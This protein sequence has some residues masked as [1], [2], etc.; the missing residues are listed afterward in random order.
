MYVLEV[1]PLSRTAPPHPLS[2][3]NRENLAPGTIISIPLRKKIVAGL[4]VASIPVREAKA[5]IKTASFSL[6]KSST[7]EVGVLPM[8]LMKAASAIALYYATTVGAVLS[9]LLVPVLPER[10]PTRFIKGTGFSIQPIEKPMLGRK[11]YYEDVL[12]E[13]KKSKGTTLLVVSTQAE[14]DEW[15]NFYK[16]LKPLVLSG[17]LS[18]KRRETAMARAV[19]AAIDETSV[20]TRTAAPSLIIATPGFSWIPIPHLSR[21]IIERVSA[22]SYVLPKRPHINIVVALTELARARNIP[23]VYG[24]YP[25]PLEYRS[26]PSK[27]LTEKPLGTITLFDV[28][29][30]KEDD[31]ITGATWKAIPDTILTQI[32]DV[33]EKNGRVAVLAVRKGYAPT[34]VCRD[35]GTA[36]IDEQGRALSL[37]I[38]NGKRILRSTDGATIESAK[39]LCKHC[40]SWNLMPLGIG[41]E[42]VEEEL[43]KTFPDSEDSII[44]GTEAM[45]STLSLEDPVDLGIVASADALLSLPFWRA[46]ER[47]VRIG[48]MLAE[49]SKKVIV[50]SRHEG[51][52]A[53]LTALTSPTTSSFW[54][55]ELALRKAL[56]YPPFGT[57]IWFLVGGSA[58][59]IEDARALITNVCAP[60]T[61]IHLAPRP[62]SASILRGISVLQLPDGAWPDETLS[63]RI[64][65]LSPVIRVHIDS[66]SL[67]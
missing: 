65:E 59:R 64:S 3:R 49:R 67:W 28:R 7:S 17:K 44:V 23:V 4:V 31:K 43:R 14:A 37:S 13:E 53:A 35:C 60:L 38:A 46:R 12:G 45:L 20:S 56:H 41:V 48:L 10:I 51:T 26:N 42:R 9:A 39:A 25:L 1:I 29:A 58:A 63:A 50:A 5:Q 15:A 34:V 47:F 57:L 19:G 30:Q 32:R 61:P 16:P 36:V 6:S 8:P 54:A 40:G 22:G 2:Y 33:L 27:P 18:G 24:D 52:D 62:I 66:E 11:K 55:D 21:I